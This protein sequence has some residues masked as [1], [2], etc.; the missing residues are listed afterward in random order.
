MRFDAAF[1]ALVS[2][3]SLMGYAHAE[4]A[5]A[6]ADASSAIE[7]PTFTVCSIELVSTFPF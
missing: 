6:A 5:E 3:A 4:E 7:R 2:S 1:T